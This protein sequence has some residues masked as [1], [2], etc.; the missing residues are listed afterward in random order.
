MEHASSDISYLAE[1]IPAVL[2]RISEAAGI[3][4]ADGLTAYDLRHFIP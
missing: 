3:K 1:L 4:F 2:Q